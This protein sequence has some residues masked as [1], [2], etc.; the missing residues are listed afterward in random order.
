MTPRKIL[1][2]IHLIAGCTA[3]L[4]IL[5]MSATGVLLTYERQMVSSIER[6]GLR[7]QVARKAQKGQMP[8][9]LEQLL[10]KV[11]AGAAL[12][13]NA[14]VV[15][16]GDATAEPV[17]LN[18]GREG[19][20]YADPYTGEILS[21]GSPD[22]RKFFQR[23]TA[24]HRW[25]GQQGGRSPARAVT[26]ASNLLFLVVVCS[27]LFIWL[28]RTWSKQSVRAVTWFRGG[29]S[30]KARDFNWHNTIGIWSLVP[31]FFV[32]SSAVP[33][34]YTW[35]NDLLYTMTGN[36]PPRPPGPQEGRAKKDG[37]REERAGKPKNGARPG[38]SGGERRE[39]EGRSREARSADAFTGIDAGYETVLARAGSWQS[40][41]MRLPN[42]ANAPLAF[43]IDEGTGG[44]PQLRRTVTLERGTNQV[45]REETFASNNLGR[46]LRMWARFVHTGEAF[47]IVGQTIAGI[48]SLGAC[49]LCYTGIALA[50]RRWAAWRARRKT[51]VEEKET[52]MVA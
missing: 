1:F 14:A 30:G 35:A 3:G 5:L 19:V 17:E 36:E 48:A 45:V 33:M 16:R 8:L 47:G 43:T 18:F 22:T 40:I 44:Q 6:D 52:V 24:W 26:G 51:K 38:E 50:I 28:P 32:V 11:S 9:P 23:V 49:V 46:R 15:M 21:H 29:L 13:P 39:G 42:N 4:I 10:A 37:P 2:W 31:L 34:S 27:G 12:P 25:L 7:L 41:T 20:L